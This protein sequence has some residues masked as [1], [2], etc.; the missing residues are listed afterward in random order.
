MGTSCSPAEDPSIS[1]CDI[2]R[3]G[4]ERIVLPELNYDKNVDLTETLN[5]RVDFCGSIATYDGRDEGISLYRT[6]VDKNSNVYLLY[7]L[8][9]TTDVSKVVVYDAHKNITHSGFIE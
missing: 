3:R 8:G 9:Q 4:N 6:G 5:R 2:I 7:I 1:E